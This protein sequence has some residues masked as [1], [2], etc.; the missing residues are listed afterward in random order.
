MRLDSK[1]LLNRGYF[2][3]KYFELFNHIPEMPDGEDWVS[4]VNLWM[5]KANKIFMPEETTFY[6]SVENDVKEVV[7]SL[8]ISDKGDDSNRAI[9]IKDSEKYVSLNL[10][11]KNLKVRYNRD[12]AP[13][14]LGEVMKTI[15]MEPKR[16]KLKSKVYR[17]WYVNFSISDHLP[18]DIDDGEDNEQM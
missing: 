7:D 10:I 3:Q 16:I 18:V 9:L 13:N 4:L 17:L 6:G 15:G 14:V 11:Q 8:P 2:R 5:E 12:V 1:S